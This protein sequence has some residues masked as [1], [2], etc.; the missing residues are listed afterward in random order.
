MERVRASTQ[1]RTKGAGDGTFDIAIIGGGVN[2]C[3]IARDAAGR[4]Y[5][6]YL[7]EQGDLASA[8]SSASTKLLHGGLRY[9]EYYEF[10]LVREALTERE[11]VWGIAPH[12]VHPLRFVLPYGRGMRPWWMLRL[13]LFLYDHMGGRKLL[14]KARALD[15][16]HDAAGAPLKGE[17]R[18]RGFEYSDCWVDDARLVVLNAADA[19][20]KGAVIETRTRAV[21]LDRAPD[22]WTL[23]VEDQATGARKA[24]RARVLV[25]AAG[26]W[27]DRQIGAARPPLKGKLRLVQGSH[28][29]VPR[30]FDHDRCYIFQNPDG[31]IVFA[32]PY[33]GDFTLI[34]TTDLDY[35]GDP[36]KPAITS[37]ET[38]YLCSAASEYFAR[39]VTPADVVWTYSGVRALYDDGA[40]A[41]QAATR[42]YVLE[43]NE[44]AAPLLSVLGGKITTYRHLALD[45][46]D[47]LRT[48]LGPAAARSGDWTGTKPLPGGDFPPGD[49]PRLAQA[50]Q[51]GHPWLTPADAARLARTYGTKAFEFLAA[52]NADPGA[53]RPFGAGLTPA[54]VRHLMR[55]EFARTVEDVIWRRTKLGLRLAPEEVASLRA[56]MAQEQTAAA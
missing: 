1:G 34:G 47:K 28:I 37:E 13:G 31:R 14:P 32:I 24:V 29:V 40:S 39:P 49:T 26:P 52:A 56:F 51:E 12:I 5:S 17:L 54:E 6:V 8:T 55:E 48:H 25:N 30:L 23:T 10:K 42:D 43:L 50:L 2:G 46:L 21:A 45:A 11:V 53:R 15:L 38:A 36:A 20:A 18:T 27:A 9:L 7:C 16:G 33:E 3:G 35:E 41:A 44:E 4:G 22:A 19:R